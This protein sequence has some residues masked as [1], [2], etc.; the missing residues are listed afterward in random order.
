[1]NRS[2]TFVICLIMIIGLILAGDT[3]VLSEDVG[4]ETDFRVEV[5]GLRISGYGYHNDTSV[6]PFSW[7]YGSTVVLLVQTESENIISFDND[8]SEIQMA[9]DDKGTNLLK[10]NKK[11]MTRRADFDAFPTYSSDYKACQLDLDFPRIPAAGAVK[12]ECAGMLVFFCASEKK[13]FEKKDV[14]LKEGTQIKAGPFFFVIS[15][16]KRPDSRADEFPM[17]V[18]F[19]TQKR[20]DTLEGVAFYDEEGREIESEIRTSGASRVIG[21]ITATRTYQLTK[22]VEKATIVF[23]CWKDFKKISV[24]FSVVTSIGLEE[25][26]E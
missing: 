21:K 5:R 6:R 18:T 13:S 10:M 23:T 9:R 7:T 1:M 19:E 11:G 17:A 16:A 25:P 3:I 14:A 8:N 12:L 2:N 22:K 24:P 15:E 26:G 4:P 20:F